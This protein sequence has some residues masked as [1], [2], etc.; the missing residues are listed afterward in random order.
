MLY[1]VITVD[2]VLRVADCESLD[3]VNGFGLRHPDATE[4]RPIDAR[5]RKF[6]IRGGAAGWNDACAEGGR[7]DPYRP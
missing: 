3:D 5:R 6:G 4:V 7:S 1:E 2:T